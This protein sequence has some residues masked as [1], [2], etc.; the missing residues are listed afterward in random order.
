MEFFNINLGTVMF[1]FYLMMA[2]IILG[3]F[4]GQVWLTVLG[5]PIFL[6]TVLG[7]SFKRRTTTDM[8]SATRRQVENKGR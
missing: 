8:P 5:L 6:S 3:V 4:T 1:R 7:I 2:V